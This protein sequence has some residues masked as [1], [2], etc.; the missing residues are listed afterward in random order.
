[1]FSPQKFDFTKVYRLKEV[2]RLTHNYKIDIPES[3]KKLWKNN[4]L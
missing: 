4:Y 1:M 2:K 3:K